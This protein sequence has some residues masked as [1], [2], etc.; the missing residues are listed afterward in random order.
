MNLSENKF[1]GQE[2]GGGEPYLDLIPSSLLEP[3]Q[4]TN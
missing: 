2:W 1:G 3:S 4:S